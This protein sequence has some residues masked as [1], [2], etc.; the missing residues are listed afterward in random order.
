[1]PIFFNPMDGTLRVKPA[2][3]K[4]FD[5]VTGE[6]YMGW[7]PPGTGGIPAPSF[8]AESALNYRFNTEEVGFY[9]QFLPDISPNGIEPP[10]STDPGQRGRLLFSDL[11]AAA[12][13]PD[14]LNGSTAIQMGG[15]TVFQPSTA[16]DAGVLTPYYFPASA[17]TTL[18]VFKTIPMSPSNNFTVFQ[19]IAGTNLVN[20]SISYGNLSLDGI[21]CVIFIAEGSSGTNVIQATVP[22]AVFS[23]YC[24]VMVT[25]NGG[26]FSAAN[27]SVK[28]N[29]TPYTFGSSPFGLAGNPGTFFQT[30]NDTN[31]PTGFFI[32]SAMWNRLLTAEELTALNDY[33]QDA[34]GLS[35]E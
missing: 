10:N 18:N 7:L 33:T 6:F 20:G 11:S 27:F 9:P 2:K 4:R 28:V 25:Y 22:V 13:V 32:E 17:F 31:V 21:T 3:P 14:A 5:A 24:T 29:G 34:Y 19:G 23:N 1:M 30:S 35:V 15:Q 12:I 26:G 16:R 8:P